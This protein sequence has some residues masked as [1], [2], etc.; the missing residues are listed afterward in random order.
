[1]KDAKVGDLVYAF[2][3][4]GKVIEIFES[5][6]VVWD[7][8]VIERKKANGTWPVMQCQIESVDGDGSRWVVG[9]GNGIVIDNILDMVMGEGI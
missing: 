1:M 6:E 5:P 3:R 9:Q 8:P 2:G 4:I 7:K